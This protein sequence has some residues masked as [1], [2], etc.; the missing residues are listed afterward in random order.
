MKTRTL[1]RSVYLLF[2]IAL[3][4]GCASQY[5]KDAGTPPAVPRYTLAELPYHD[6]W[7]GIV[8]NGA[9]IG[10]SHFK[11]DK[12]DTAGQYELRSEAAFALHFFGL[13]K[14]FNLKSRD[15]VN[16]DLTLVNFYYDLDLDGNH[17][18]LHGQVQDGALGVTTRTHGRSDTKII[19]LAA[20]LYPSSILY[21]YPL[22]HGLEIGREYNYSVYS[23]ET[24]TVDPVEQKVEGYETSKLFSG[25]A[26]KLSTHLQGQGTST[27]L[28]ATGLPVFELA[29]SGV[30][31]SAL[32]NE[33]TARRYLAQAVLNKQDVLL[34]FSLVPVDHAIPAPRTLRVLELR[35]TGLNAERL[36]PADAFQTCQ[37]SSATILCQMTAILPEALRTPGPAVAP[38]RTLQ[39]SIAVT[40]TDPRIRA[41]A[42]QITADATTDLEKIQHLV[43][44]M[45]ANIK[46]E[47]MDAFSALDVLDSKRAEC[48]GHAYLY[49]AFARSLGIPTR[50]QN[51]LMYSEVPQGFLYHSWNESLVNGHWLPVDP[52]FGQVGADATHVKLV[53]GE[54]PAELLPLLDVIGKLQA[55]VL[56]FQ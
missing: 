40:S 23:G 41:A 31:I 21:L 38:E 22:L 15:R 4:N 36:P 55:Q 48:Q 20:P 8:F 34:D 5:F 35:F 9:K 2:A 28:D 45:Q 53:E 25:P 18:L 24:G 49:A 1:L 37:T 11:L 42:A 46:R 6:Y 54:S 27:W 19:K 43:Q 13:E 3:L 7:T 29:M 26:F 52:T 12:A 44:W 14:K 30:L 51:G 56:S 16:A 50:V 10:F 33:Q 17:Q 39:P 47:P 32:E